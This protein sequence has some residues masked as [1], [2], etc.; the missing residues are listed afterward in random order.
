MKRILGAVALLVLFSGPVPAVMTSALYLT[1]AYDFGEGWQHGVQVL[2]G[3]SPD[4]SDLLIN[5]WEKAPWALAP[6]VSGGTVRIA[7]GLDGVNGAA[8]AEYTTGGIATGTSYAYNSAYPEDLDLK[9]TV[10][11]TTDGTFNYGFGSGPN[12]QSK[13]YKWNSDWSNPTELLDLSDLDLQSPTAITYGG[14]NNLWVSGIRNDDGMYESTEYRVFN[15]DMATGDILST[16]EMGNDS[17]FL[18]MDYADG[19]LWT[20]DIYTKTLYQ[21]STSGGGPLSYATSEFLYAGGEF[22]YGVVPEPG[23]FLLFGSVLAA[24]GLMR[25]RRRRG[26]RR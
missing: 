14:S 22:E 25:W 13:I 16:F 21:Y 8:G 26:T 23:T 12:S 18:A 7:P 9:V 6:A 17:H 10:D 20:Q 1:T 2:Q 5:G 3:N 11:A 4:A 19:T 24:C 15:I